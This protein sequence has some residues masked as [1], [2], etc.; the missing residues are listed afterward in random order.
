MTTEVVL[1]IIGVVIAEGTEMAPWLAKRLVHWSARIRYMDIEHA[2]MRAEELEAVIDCR[3]GKL[4]KLATA[5]GFVITALGPAI[6]RQADGLTYEA[7]RRVLNILVGGNRPLRWLPSKM[8]IYLVHVGL[9][10][11]LGTSNRGTAEIFWRHKGSITF[12]SNAVDD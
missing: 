6:R 10:M 7:G 5:V 12:G 3:P 1:L 4:F 9:S 11:Y 2:Q 8:G